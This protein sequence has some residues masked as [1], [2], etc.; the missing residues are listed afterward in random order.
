MASRHTT[1]ERSERPGR[2]G[3]LLARLPTLAFRAGLAPALGKRLLLL[4]HTGRAS[5]LTWHTVLE[6]VAYD[7]ENCS[8]TV[9][10]GF[11]PDADWYRNLRRNPKT[12]LQFGNRH[13]AVTAHFLTSDEGASVMARYA[14]RYPRTARRRC[15]VIGHPVDGSE[16][17]Y[18]EVGRSIPFVRLDTS[19]GAQADY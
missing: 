9:A 4:H 19:Q 10:S 3:R 1:H 12:V 11:G 6:V 15:A 14:R 16:A 18:R 8:W 2:G 17:E 5:G 13:H 7:P